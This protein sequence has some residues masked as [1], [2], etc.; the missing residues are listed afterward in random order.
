MSLH[1]TSR[2]IGQELLG[3]VALPA[4]I[5][6]AHITV[7]AMLERAPDLVAPYVTD[8]MMDSRS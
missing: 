4:V 2:R 7:P 6:T 5:G 1:K 8:V 3:L